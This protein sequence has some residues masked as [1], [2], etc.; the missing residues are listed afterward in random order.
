M[1][2]W[3]ADQIRS[4]FAKPFDE[5]P[6]QLTI[7]L[8]IIEFGSNFVVTSKY[9]IYDFIP[10]NLFE[11]FRR[12]ANFYFLLLAM[13]QFVPGIAPVNPILNIMP[14]LFVLTVSAIKEA[15]EDYFRHKQDDETNNQFT[16]VYNDGTKEF[17]DVPWKDVHVGQLVKVCDREFIP[18]DL[19][20]LKTN[21]PNSVCYIETANLDGETNLKSRQAHQDIE[22]LSDGNNVECFRK[23]TIDYEA[24]N[25]HLYK[26]QGNFSIDS[27]PKQ[28]L[29]ND[30]VLLRGSQLRNTEWAIGVAIYTGHDTKLMKNAQQSRIK[31]SSIEQSLNFYI[32]TVFGIL[33]SVSILSGF[34]GGDFVKEN[35]TDSWYLGFS[36]DED[37]ISF[38]G[39]GTITYI[40]LYNTLIPIS[41]Y[42]SIE[43]VKLAQAF[44]INSDLAMYY[45]ETDTP[46]RARTS[47][48]SDEL[49]EIEYIFSD[50]TG[51]LTRNIMEMRK[52]AIGNHTYDIGGPNGQLSATI[53]EHMKREDRHARQI[54]S[55]FEHIAVCHS[56]IPEINKA[57][58]NDNQAIVYQAAS[59]D[60]GALVSAARDLGIVF[61]ARTPNK[62]TVEVLGEV[63]EW[64][65]LN[66]IEFTSDRKRMSV[67]AS[68]PD[69]TIVIFCKGADSIMK[70]RLKLDQEVMFKKVEK[71]LE[72]FG[73][74]GL[75]TL[76]MASRALD[77]AEYATWSAKFQQAASSLNDREAL[78]D[79]CA[80]DLECEMELIGASAVEDKL[81]DGVPD[82][83]HT[84][85]KA[86][87]KVWV[88]TGDKQETAINIGFSCRLM[89]REMSQDIFNFDDAETVKSELVSRAKKLENSRNQY[90]LSDRA[91]IIDGHTLGLVLSSCQSEFMNYANYCKSV[92]C[93]RVSPSQK[94]LIVKMV[95]KYAN[96]ITLAIGDGAND[97]SMIKEAHIGVGISGQEGMQAVM[98]SDYAIAQF[99]FLEPLLLI[100]GRWSYIR[101]SQI[102]RYC[103]Y[104]NFVFT[105]SN[106]WF[107][108]Y[109]G[110]SGQ[111][112]LDSFYISVYNVFYTSLPIMFLAV[113]D[114]DVSKDMMKRHPQLYVERQKTYRFNGQ[115]FSLALF[116]GFI[117]S[118]ICFYF[119]YLVFQNTTSTLP[120]G[121][122][123]GDGVFV[124]G[125]I[126]YT[127]II[128]TANLRVAFMTKYWTKWNVFVV[129]LS[130]FGWFLITMGYH[131]VYN[132]VIGEMYNV[133][134]MLYQM[135]AFW[136]TILA[137]PVLCCMLDFAI[138]SAHTHL[139]PSCVDIIRE[140]EY[141]ANSKNQNAV[142][143]ASESQVQNSSLTPQA[144][145]S[146][147]SPSSE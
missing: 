126:A 80:Q 8:P 46:A 2:D 53:K 96:A 36:K 107:A 24:P 110:F 125:T 139:R 131:A 85:R 95:K 47:N 23:I 89:E 3:F 62:L 19:V 5:S 115:G 140:M 86:G 100:H 143:P 26:F 136:F 42:I 65:L 35:R 117:H 142:S 25:S 87:I 98:S 108:I 76:V 82:C 120:N 72:L 56:V 63:R 50:K 6:R 51:T 37:Y 135:P 124:L 32:I 30:H 66:V 4:I 102:I 27:N 144:N 33:V 103:F 147:S 54:I 40:L 48:L 60:E 38:G 93:C 113:L 73:I 145:K 75:R 77:K 141:K 10:R 58:A 133:I 109:C 15:R 18:T 59:P 130:I 146:P 57:N 41:L 14:L 119:P 138:E 13:I 128:L 43:L 78:I 122:S 132:P 39:L 88:L 137:T 69:G 44:L 118:I 84:L 111:T 116:D 31:T 1:A 45:K 20:L 127:C 52:C 81:Q 92:I 121:Q 11:Q 112:F 9:H 70:E 68:S 28:P 12:L 71:D 123:G 7:G 49:G 105:L 22:A 129:L 97:V 29:T 106:F 74:E 61:K 17:V 104:K 90:Q 99:R 94:A 101:I 64:T 16:Y 55:F 134:F 114:Q 34:L 79:Q 21:T 67:I 91:L 83:I